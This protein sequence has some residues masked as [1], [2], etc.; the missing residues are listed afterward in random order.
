MTSR[1]HILGW[2][3]PYG[4]QTTR[5]SQVSPAPDSFSK[6]KHLDTIFMRTTA[7]TTNTMYGRQRAGYYP[8]EYRPRGSYHSIRGDRPAPGRGTY[9]GRGGFSQSASTYRP[10]YDSSRSASTYRPDYDAHV[11]APSSD[12]TTRGTQ[13]VETRGYSFGL[14]ASRQLEEQCKDLLKREIS[15]EKQIL[16]VSREHRRREP[17][18]ESAMVEDIGMVEIQHIAKPELHRPAASLGLCHKTAKVESKLSPS[19]VNKLKEQ[20]EKTGH[21]SSPKMKQSANKPGA[22][23]P[24][25]KTTTD[26]DLGQQSIMR[27]T[28]RDDKNPLK[29]KASQEWTQRNSVT[30][31]GID[32]RRRGEHK[33][34]DG[35]EA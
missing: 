12:T 30:E 2:D 28:M 31:T 34:S 20:Q 5:V 18:P 16:S 26:V 27:P 13:T 19:P 1:V 21:E 9:R 32:Q 35:A 4:Y 15:P 11:A 10:N 14:E 23:T 3:T 7:N 25:S 22:S 17:I 6:R 8:R 29:R 33:T 24:L